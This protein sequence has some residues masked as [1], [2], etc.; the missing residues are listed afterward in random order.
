M[1]P[2]FCL[3]YD[4]VIDY[5]LSNPVWTIAYNCCKSSVRFSLVCGSQQEVSPV[6][7]ENGEPRFSATHFEP[8]PTLFDV[9][10]DQL[11]CLVPQRREF[12]SRLSHVLTMWFISVLENNHCN[13]L[14]WRLWNSISTAKNRSCCLFIRRQNKMCQ[15]QGQ[16]LWKPWESVRY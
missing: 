9:Q 12:E 8:L 3:F 6:G 10:I 11:P 16:Y 2:F 7:A 15:N 4:Y 5:H 14:W 13:F 1:H